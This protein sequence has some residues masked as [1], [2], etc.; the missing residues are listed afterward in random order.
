MD[1]SSS[2]CPPLPY[3]FV[4]RVSTC[5]PRR[6]V[7]SGTCLSIPPSF[8]ANICP[9]IFT[10]CRSPNGIKGAPFWFLS[11][12]FRFFYRFQL[13]SLSL[14]VSFYRWFGSDFLITMS[15]F[16][17]PRLSLADEAAIRK[18][19]KTVRATRY[20]DPV[21]QD[22]FLVASANSVVHPRFCCQK[23]SF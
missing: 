8:T 6:I 14:P 20:E 10:S 16:D 12:L 23:H 15:A 3:V 22:A 7:V 21:D 5:P 9:Q 2:H 11:S 18:L 13:A 4:S 17:A 19:L 1:F